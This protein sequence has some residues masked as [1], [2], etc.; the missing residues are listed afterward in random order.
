MC[1]PLRDQS[2]KVRYYL[3]AQLDISDLIYDCTGLA[4]LSKLVE[5]HD[6]NRIQVTSRDVPKDSLQ[7]DE[8]DQLSE[9]LDSQELERLVNLRRR[10]QLELEEKI[11]YKDFGRNQGREEE[12][13]RTSLAKLDN[14]FQ[15]NGQGSAP[16][17]GY[18]KTVRTA[19]NSPA[20]DISIDFCSTFLYDL[21]HLFAFCLHLLICVYLESY[22]RL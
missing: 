13:L 16:P 11:V 12:S 1:V 18:Y 9:A 14:D 17:L 10:K 8:F 5:R 2:G 4:S 7:P 21:L 20:L 19:S 15:L 6:E 3:G 22:N